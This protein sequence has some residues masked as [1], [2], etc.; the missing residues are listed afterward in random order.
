MNFRFD[1]S[2][3]LLLYLLATYVGILRVFASLL[4]FIRSL[5]YYKSIYHVSMTATEMA[6]FLYL[7]KSFT[8]TLEWNVNQIRSSYYIIVDIILFKK[9]TRTVENR[10]I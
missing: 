2:G 10:R 1:C 6:L 4:S 9:E 8:S 7:K 3:S 5:M